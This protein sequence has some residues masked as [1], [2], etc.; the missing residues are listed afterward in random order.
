[1]NDVIAAFEVPPHAEPR[2]P[3]RRTGRSVLLNGGVVLVSGALGAL[4]VSLTGLAGL[5]GWF[6]ATI[7]VLPPIAGA[8]E[9]RRGVRAVTSRI[10]GASVLMMFVSVALPW[11]SI[12]WTVIGRGAKAF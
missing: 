3:W 11:V 12:I 7:L 10:V 2:R 6:V 8:V 9:M 1:M 5:L 4:A